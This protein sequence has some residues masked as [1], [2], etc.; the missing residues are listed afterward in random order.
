MQM[1]KNLRLINISR[2]PTMIVI[3][4][5]Q[6][7]FFFASLLL[8]QIGPDKY[9]NTVLSFLPFLQ[10]LRILQLILTLTYCICK[11]A[12]K[13][14]RVGPNVC[15]LTVTI[16]ILLFATYSATVSIQWKLCKQCFA[17]VFMSLFLLNFLF[18]I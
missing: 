1:G 9:Q 18:S 15:V 11:C 5:V 6:D 16:E 10:R 12:L 2:S 8:M 14:A 4:A 7:G 3:A 13:E 17:K